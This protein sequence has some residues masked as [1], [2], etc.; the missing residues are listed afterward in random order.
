MHAANQFAPVLDKKTFFNEPEFRAQLGVMLGLQ[1]SMN[2]IVFH[3]WKERGLAWHRAIYIEAGELLDHM[4]T[5]KWWKKGT[6]DVPQAVMEL[7]DIWHFGLSWYIGRFGQTVGSESLVQGITVRVRAAAETY[8]WNAAPS[9][10]YRMEKVDD[11]VA[12]A[13]D[14]RFATEPFVH[15]MASMGMDFS[16]LF[17]RYVG[18]NALNRFRQANGYKQGTYI[19]EWEGREDNVHLDEILHMLRQ[20]PSDQ[21]MAAVMGHLEGRYRDLFSHSV[22]GGKV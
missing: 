3:D 12:A 14:Q 15:L 19:K 20:T 5:W 8:N 2:A 13:G 6:P 18:K 1:D 16:T 21:L 4:G 22:A 9:D 7:V 17:V 10:K 11:L